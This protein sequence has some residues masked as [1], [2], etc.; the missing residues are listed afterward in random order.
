MYLKEASDGTKHKQIVKDTETGVSFEKYGHASDA[1]DYLITSAFKSEM[2]IFDK[3]VRGVVVESI[4]QE[5]PLSRY[6]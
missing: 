5:K 2:S 1:I 3:G 6:F 4:E